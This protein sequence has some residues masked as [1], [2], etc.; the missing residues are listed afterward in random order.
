MVKQAYGSDGKDLGIG[1]DILVRAA[2][3]EEFADATGRYFDNDRGQFAQP[4]PDA[5]DAS[6]NDQLVATIDGIVA[7]WR[8]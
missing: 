6:K 2:T 5:L 3:S 1:A 7:N 4:H 8:K